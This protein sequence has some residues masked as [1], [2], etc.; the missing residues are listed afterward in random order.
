MPCVRNGALQR[1]FPLEGTLSAR[2]RPCRQQP[3]FPSYLARARTSTTS[4]SM[5]HSAGSAP[6]SSLGCL[7]AGIRQQERRTKRGSGHRDRRRGRCGLRRGQG[8]AIGAGTGLLFGSAVGTS[9]ASNTYGLRIELYAGLRW[10]S[11][12]SRT[13]L[14]AGLPPIVSGSKHALATVRQKW[15]NGMQ[16]FVSPARRA[17]GKQ[18]CRIQNEG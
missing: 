15:A 2:A 3:A 12:R 13:S 6:V 4:A 14:K 7:G 5:M 18:S 16:R 8:A 10:G 9:A 17:R 11:R 1:C